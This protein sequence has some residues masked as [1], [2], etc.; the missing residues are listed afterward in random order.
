MKSTR[1]NTVFGA[2]SIMRNGAVKLKILL[3]SFAGLHSIGAQA[4]C[5]DE[6]ELEEEDEDEDEDKH[7]GDGPRDCQLGYNEIPVCKKCETKGNSFGYR[8]S[9]SG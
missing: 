4:N 6:E 3:K 1:Q 9:E 8:Y 5:E 7:K 2:D